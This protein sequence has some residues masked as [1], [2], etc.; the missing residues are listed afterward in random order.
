MELRHQDASPDERPPSDQWA[1]TLLP[2]C[3]DFVV[4]VSKIGDTYFGY[5]PNLT[6][7][8]IGCSIKEYYFGLSMLITCLDS[9]ERVADKQRWLNG[10]R[11]R[12]WDVR[13]FGDAVWIASVHV[14]VILCDRSTFSHFD[15]IYLLSDEPKIKQFS[16]S[17]Y[18]TDGSTFGDAVPHTFVKRFFDFGALR[19]LSDGC[20]LNFAC[21]S[22]VLVDRI[23]AM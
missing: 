14:P 8:D 20:G 9:C 3:W 18:T 23:R 17:H 19:Y 21:E 7:Y 15:E 11:D 1:A 10:L 13:I 22:M 5:S 4:K 12:S 2:P 6:I 16:A